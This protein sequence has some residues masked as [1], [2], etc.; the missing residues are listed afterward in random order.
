MSKIRA[1]LV[2]KVRQQKLEGL[3]AARLKRMSSIR[4]KLASTNYKLN[5][6]QDLGGC[7]VILPSINDVEKFSKAYSENVKHEIKR[8]DDYIVQPRQSGYRSKHVILA[9]S[10][11]GSHEIYNGRNIEVQ[12]RTRLQHSWAT[13]VEAVG[14]FT[15]AN[16]K[17][18][19]GNIGWLRLFRLMSE[20]MARAERC[21][22][23][24]EF[25]SER[26]R[27]QEIKSLENELDAIKTLE[28]LSQAFRAFDT[29]LAK[30]TEKFHSYLVSYDNVNFTV[31]VQPIFRAAD[32]MR[33]YDLAEQ[34]D[35]YSGKNTKNVVLVDAM[36][37]DLLREAFPNYFGD[38]QLFK[39]NLQLIAAGKNIEEY[40]V[41]PLRSPPP[42]DR[43]SIDLSWMR[44]TGKSK[45]RK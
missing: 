22:L 30:P 36:K 5:Q 18:S 16:M 44:R 3:T 41:P 28:N 31:D 17:G 27:R 9:F 7:R 8:V 43:S 13:A 23:R 19:E 34:S 38:V 42:F 37:V 20:E 11:S 2:G 32:W 24:S 39:R 35:N 33:S 15:G 40:T 1:E 45:W 6:I 25:N 4:R 10:G 21:A 26:L 12:I 14:T 29:S